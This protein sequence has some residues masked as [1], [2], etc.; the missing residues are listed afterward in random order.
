MNIQKNFY[1]YL[2]TLIH[3]SYRPVIEMTIPSS[4]DR[5][6]VKGDGEVVSLFTQYTPYS[7]A[8]R[9]WTEASREIYAR[10]GYSKNSNERNSSD[11][12]VL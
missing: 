10:R 6:L 9:P 4:V 5:S 11:K 8:E 1:E 3:S 2:V 7:P 12:I